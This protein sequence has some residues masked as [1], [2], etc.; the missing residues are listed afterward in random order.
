MAYTVRVNADLLHV[1]AVDTEPATRVVAGAI[2]LRTYAQGTEFARKA[3]FFH[4]AT[5]SYLLRRKDGGVYFDPTTN[6]LAGTLVRLKGYARGHTFIYEEV[7]V[8]QT[9]RG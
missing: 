7:V 9:A 3:P 1:A 4:T 5:G 2:T 8:Q 6:K